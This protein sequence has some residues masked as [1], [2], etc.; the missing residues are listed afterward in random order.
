MLIH[1]FCLPSGPIT[2][3]KALQNMAANTTMPLILI[4]TAF[5]AVITAHMHCTLCLWY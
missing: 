5:Q 4:T 2:D 1:K 3:T